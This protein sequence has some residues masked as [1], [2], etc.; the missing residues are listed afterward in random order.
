M[1]TVSIIALL[2]LSLSSFGSTESTLNSCTQKAL[3]TAGL[4]LNHGKLS[5][6]VLKEMNQSIKVCKDSVKDALKAEKKTAQ[7]AKIMAQIA[8]LTAKLK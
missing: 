5:K 1:K 7:K 3:T 2:T 6:D 4:S 8:K